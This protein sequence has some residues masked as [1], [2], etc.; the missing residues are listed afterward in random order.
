MLC[1]RARDLSDQGAGL[2][3]HSLRR[4]QLRNLVQRYLVLMDSAG[5]TW[6][7]RGPVS[8]SEVVASPFRDGLVWTLTYSLTGAVMG[9]P[10][11]VQL[12]TDGR[13]CR[14]EDR[15][16]LW[17]CGPSR[18]TI[19]GS[20]GSMRV[21][22]HGTGELHE[23]PFPE[24]EA[25]WSVREASAWVDQPAPAMDPTPTTALGRTARRYRGKDLDLTVD[26]ETGFVVRVSRIGPRGAMLLDGRECGLVRGWP[27]MFD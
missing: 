18:M 27:G 2:R 22:Q 9:A 25:L 13:N 6:S 5:A 15:R 23:P 26:E 8:P 10:R 19:R 16:T 17:I 4:D 24:L 14:A 12:W 3:Q 11:T 1:G 21:L 20:D 7:M